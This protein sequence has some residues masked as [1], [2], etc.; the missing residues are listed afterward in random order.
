MV[1]MEQWR[2]DLLDLIFSPCMVLLIIHLWLDAII[3]F[4]CFV[5]NT[6][7]CDVFFN[8]N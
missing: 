2:I 6:G 3:T 7:S 5:Y 4:S 1:Q 8:N